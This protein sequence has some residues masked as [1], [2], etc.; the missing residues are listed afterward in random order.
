MIRRNIE[1]V[2]LIRSAS[3]GQDGG[4]RDGRREVRAFY[5]MNAGGGKSAL[6]EPAVDCLGNGNGAGKPA[7]RFFQAVDSM[8]KLIEN[9]V[10]GH[11]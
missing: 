3:R 10:G 9:P 8:A 5:F 1:N 6:R 11:A 7:P 2:A 4:E